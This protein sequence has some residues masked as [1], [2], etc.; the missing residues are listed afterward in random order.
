M[1]H[2]IAQDSLDFVGQRSINGA[3]HKDVGTSNKDITIR[4]D[5][6]SANDANSLRASRCQ[7]DL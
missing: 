4:L 7:A 5:K 2:K 1:S 6:H 3:E